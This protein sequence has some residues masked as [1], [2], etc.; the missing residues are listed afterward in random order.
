M[1]DSVV[2]YVD[3]VCSSVE[4]CLDK[5]IIVHLK[6]WKS[7]LHVPFFR[8]DPLLL[9]VVVVECLVAFAIR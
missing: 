7:K 4:L 9:E 8:G 1:S 3:T 5:P 2:H 6:L